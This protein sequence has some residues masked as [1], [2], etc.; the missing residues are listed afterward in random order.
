MNET[1]LNLF[2]TQ[3]RMKYPTAERL[4]QIQIHEADPSDIGLPPVSAT[5]AETDQLFDP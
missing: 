3:P 1:P 5:V 2:K 4:P